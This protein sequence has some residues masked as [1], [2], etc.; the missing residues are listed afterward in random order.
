MTYPRAVTAELKRF[1]LDNPDG[2]HASV[3]EDVERLLGH[4]DGV[5]RSEASLRADDT[6][7]LYAV[8]GPARFVVWV[9]R[10]DDNDLV[11]DTAVDPTQPSGSIS[12]TLG[13]GQVDEIPIAKTVD[14]ATTLRA[15]R[16]YLE[17]QSLDGHTVWQHQGP[18]N[19]P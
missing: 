10:W 17:S 2:L 9:Q 11:I 4:L 14:L 8:G 12:V 19:D 5:N 16:T 1:S 15:A 7:G 13:N 18:P 3:W 6:T